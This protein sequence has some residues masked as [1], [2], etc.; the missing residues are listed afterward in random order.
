MKKERR[1]IQ[2]VEVGGQLLE[3][4]V[5]EGAPMLLRDLAHKAG[6]TSAKAHPYLVS[7]GNIGLIQ[8]DPLSG[9]YELGRF[10]LQMGL[11]SLQLLD[12]V[13]LAL[14]ETAALCER[15]GHTVGLAV[16][17]NA[18]PTIV[19][20]NESRQPI[21][22]KMRTGTVMSILNTA[23]GRVFSAYLPAAQVE[24]LSAREL[25]DDAVAGP[26]KAD[27]A[28]LLAEVRQRGMARTV[29][30][31]TAGINTISAPV[32]DHAGNISLAVTVIGPMGTLDADW[33]GAAATQLKLAA[34]RISQ[35]MGYGGA[36]TRQPIALH[37]S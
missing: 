25:G 11:I 28:I 27:F 22:V 14:P 13:K 15:I 9:R 12:P 31:P 1:G 5:S 34:E 20:L 16:L 37:G 30:D 6:M 18:G 10:A 35:R 24:K 8:Q 2:S 7:F 23:T 26:G 17:G 3:A 32:F 29:G 33:D 21:H 36:A 4:L 19:H